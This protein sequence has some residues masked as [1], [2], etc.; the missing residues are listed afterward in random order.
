[1]LRHEQR[2][3]IL[4]LHHRQVGARQIA[5]TLGVARGTVKKV[6]RSGSATPPRLER[7]EK[8]TTFR[9]EILELHARCRG[10]LQRVHE[11]LLEQGAELSYQ[12]LTA[13]CRRHGIGVTTRTAV[14]EYHFAPGQEIQHDTSPHRAVVAGKER[15]VQT[16]AAPLC[17][18]HMLFFQ[19]YPSFDRFHCKVFLTEAFRYH[20]GVTR[21]VMVD[22]THVVVLRGTGGDMVPVPE[23]AAF[24]DRFG[25]TFVAHEKGDANRSA[26]VERSFCF[27]ENNFLAGRAFAS[28][29]DLNQQAR[30]WCD[31]V[32]ASYKKHLRARPVELYA[33]ERPELTPLPVWVPEPY[34]LHHRTVDARGYVNLHGNRYSVPVDWIGRLVEVTETWTEVTAMLDHRRRV[35]HARVVDGVNMTVSKP[36]HRPPRGTVRQ[37]PVPE[38]QL[39]VDKLPEVADYVAALKKNGKKQVTLALRQ[40]LRMVR[41]YPQAPLLAA[42]AEAARFGLYELDRVERM[43]IRRL[44]SDYFLLGGDGD[45]R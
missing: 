21:R 9:A 14:G 35:A 13:F 7:E 28:F 11:E 41:E 40:L 4:E 33:V 17:Y 27:F 32:N 20:R 37:Q 26:V 36:E 31:K 34:R 42:L 44:A 29:A 1:M 38:E 25:F 6:I 43:V 3:A 39:I 18:S 15:L 5:K 24:A 22:N 16:A 30:A 45:D 12:A 8:A 2:A 19:C 10:N 23:M